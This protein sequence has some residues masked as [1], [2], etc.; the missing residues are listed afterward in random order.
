MHSNYF[1]SSILQY[2]HFLPLFQCVWE[3]YECVTSY[4]RN[5]LIRSDIWQSSDEIMSLYLALNMIDLSPAY[6][7]ASKTSLV[8]E[9]LM[10]CP[11]ATKYCSS[12]I[13]IISRR[14]VLPKLTTH[15][16]IVLY[17]FMNT[18]AAFITKSF[19]II[20]PLSCQKRKSCFHVL[21]HILGGKEGHWT[22]QCHI[23]YLN[24]V[25]LTTSICFTEVLEVS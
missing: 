19:L 2:Y 12:D 16:R 17:K 3:K 8:L 9:I 20:S 22:Q 14:K 11:A 18:Y 15:N 1:I 5:K 25:P 21:P 23:P 6:Q 7:L 13:G 24:T 4:M 10:L